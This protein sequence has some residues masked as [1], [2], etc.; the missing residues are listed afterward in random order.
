VHS[1]PSGEFLPSC[2]ITLIQYV[3]KINVLSVNCVFLST[4]FVLNTLQSDK[5]FNS[6]SA[7]AIE[8]W[9]ETP[10]RVHVIFFVRL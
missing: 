1:S 7:V 3:R 9:S 2:L 4:A 6:Y 10:V 5:Y 8:V